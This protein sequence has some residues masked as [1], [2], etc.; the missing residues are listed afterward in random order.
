MKIEL[1]ANWGGLGDL[2]CMAYVA[3]GIKDAGHEVLFY[4]EGDGPDPSKCRRPAAAVLLKMLDQTP[5]VGRRGIRL[6]NHFPGY[7]FELRANGKAI[8]DGLNNRMDSWCSV[9]PFP[10]EPR[11]PDL[12]IP[13]DA[14]KWAAKEYAKANGRIVAL[15]PEASFAS[16]QWPL[17]KWLDLSIMLEDEGMDVR[18]FLRH[19][20][21]HEA[22]K[23]K[24]WGMF[25]GTTYHATPI[26]RLVAA[27][28]VTP[29][30]V[31]ADSGGAHLAAV[32]GSETVVA[33]GPT[34]GVF[35]HYENAHE[36]RVSPETVRC[37]GCHFQKD[38][39]RV[40]CNAGCD[41]L[42]HLPVDRVFA[43]AMELGAAHA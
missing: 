28:A 11:Q 27:L 24:P 39:M 40:A 30:T 8:R 16:R 6:G 25:R 43:A 41:A 33:C 2:V 7:N 4:V 18:V 14:G 29:V 20:E 23:G 21:D 1:N 12:T 42:M 31:S 35:N 26:D 10:V 19:P 37:V 38:R 9:F 17:S 34:V 32:A 5:C 13:F 22:Y 15:F 3:E 36:L